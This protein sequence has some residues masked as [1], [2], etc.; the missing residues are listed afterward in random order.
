VATN[1]APA[2]ALTE[3]AEALGFFGKVLT[4][5]I[6]CI[7]SQLSLLLSNSGRVN[8]KPVQGNCFQICPPLLD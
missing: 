1:V 2:Q 8:Q 3:F 5:F 4:L 6:A 7:A